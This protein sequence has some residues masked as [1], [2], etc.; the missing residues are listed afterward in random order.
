MRVLVAEDDPVTREVLVAQLKAWGYDSVPA[1][2]G[3]Q[4]LKHLRDPSGPFLAILDW[5]LPGMEGVELC[6]RTRA[7]RPDGDQVYLIILTSRGEKE[8]LI[9]ALESGADDYL[10][11]PF[12]SGELRA[13][14]ETGARVVELQRRLAGR[15]EELEAALERERELQ[16]LLPICS[17][18][19][20]VRDDGAYWQ[21]LEEYLGTRNEVRFSHSICPS[22]Y[23]EQFREELGPL[24]P[25]DTS[26]GDGAPASHPP[27]TPL[28]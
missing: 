28:G 7:D 9:A 14:V 3:L 4:A 10:T 20:N 27:G 18:C 21:S 16:A 1:A 26:E 17:Y 11:K 23:D 2:D 25:D 15:V 5:M 19:R 13:R 22:C 6:R 8:D 24:D 12:H